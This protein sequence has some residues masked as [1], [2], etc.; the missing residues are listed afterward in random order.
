MNE[1]EWKV[2]VYPTG[3]DKWRVQLVTKD[4]EYDLAEGTKYWA[5]RLG[6]WEDDL[7]CYAFSVKQARRRGAK[8]IKRCSKAWNH[9]QTGSRLT[10]TADAHVW[11]SKPSKE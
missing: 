3:E 5:E 4:P 11:D 1:P 7:W 9:Q 8:I 6:L 2:R 10:L